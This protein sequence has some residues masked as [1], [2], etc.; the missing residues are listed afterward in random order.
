MPLI[1]LDFI[2]RFLAWLIWWICR[3]V[4]MLVTLTRRLA[5]VLAELII[6]KKIVLSLVAALLL[7]QLP[8]AG[9]ILALLALTF[10]VIAC[11]VEQAMKGLPPSGKD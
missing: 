3:I 11:L 8:V 2:S 1:R 6:D 5:S 9:E 10:A 7:L 4:I